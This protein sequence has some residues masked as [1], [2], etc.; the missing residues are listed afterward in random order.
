MGD[1]IIK[2]DGTDINERSD[3]IRTIYKY[4]PGEK[5]TITVIRE[6][7]EVKIDVVF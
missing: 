5:A 4:R 6:N 3:L 2:I 7:K 1:I